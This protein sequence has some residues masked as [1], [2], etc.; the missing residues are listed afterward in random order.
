MPALRKSLPLI[1]AL[2]FLGQAAN[3]RAEV[4][5]PGWRDG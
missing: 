2:A 5:H 1:L 3:L 4:R